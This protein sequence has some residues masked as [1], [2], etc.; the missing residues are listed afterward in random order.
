MK[1]FRYR[2]PDRVNNSNNLRISDSE[3]HCQRRTAAATLASPCHPPSICFA[4]PKRPFFLPAN[5]PLSLPPN[6]TGS[7]FFGNIGL[8]KIRADPNT[9]HLREPPEISGIKDRL[10]RSTPA[11]PLLTGFLR[12]AGRSGFLEA[13]IFRGV[14]KAVRSIQLPARIGNLAG[15]AYAQTASQLSIR[16]HFPSVAALSTTRR[17]PLL[18]AGGSSRR[19]LR[20]SR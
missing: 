1:R 8:L 2:Q 10:N 11:K 3:Q 5:H 17:S 12:F 4:R 18:K 14:R 15:S 13:G 19:A 16:R 20:T 6:G 7:F 9:V